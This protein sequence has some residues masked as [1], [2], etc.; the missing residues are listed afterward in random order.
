MRHLPSTLIR[1]AALAVM[2]SGGAS[3]SAQSHAE[4][5]PPFT[6]RAST[7]STL[8]L[9]EQQAKDAGI[10]RAADKALLNVVVQRKGPAG[11]TQTVTAH[12]TAR[13]ISLAGVAQD[14]TFK[15]NKENN[16]VSYL[17]VYTV[18]PNEMVDITVTAKPADAEAPLS[19][20]FREGMGRAQ[21]D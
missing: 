16:H 18:L 9:P 5:R 20:S 3:A 11:D 6:L 13:V 4:N 12:V 15:A 17:G 8:H 7:V 2:L 14:V 21:A 10:E 19:L 1:A